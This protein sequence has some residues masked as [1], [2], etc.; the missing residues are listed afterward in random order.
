MSR[1]AFERKDNTVKVTFNPT[2]ESVVIKTNDAAHGFSTDLGKF[3]YHEYSG[4]VERVID[5]FADSNYIDTVKAKFP[6]KAEHKKTK[7][8]RGTL[9]KQLGKAFHDEWKYLHTKAKP[10]D[11]ELDKAVT[12]CI[13]PKSY[14]EVNILSDETFWENPFVRKD[15]INFRAACLASL[16]KHKSMYDWEIGGYHSYEY[17]KWKESYD[18]EQI[19]YTSLNKTLP[20]INFRIPWYMLS[21]GFRQNRLPHP[22]KLREQIVSHYTGAMRRSATRNVN[23]NI[24]LDADEVEWIETKKA[25][26]KLMCVDFRKISSLEGLCTYLLDYNEKYEGSL[27]GLLRRSEEWHRRIVHNRNR[28]STKYSDDTPTAKL[29]AELNIE[30]IKFLGTVGEIIEEGQKMS[31]CVASYADAAVK[32]RSYIFHIEYK[33]QM[34]TCEITSFGDDYRINQIHGPNNQDNKA[35]EWG[36]KTING[37]ISK[38]LNKVTKS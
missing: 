3:R 13:G 2:K 21:G 11:L 5:Y 19:T 38:F 14:T 35:S 6:V 25:F 16:Y 36:K 7:W 37:W 10:D 22:Y 30:G 33:N 26:K 18:R 34:A 9:Y 17:T 20:A 29:P 28:S 24:L 12:R 8:L 1:F 23:I 31:H 15:C 32:G 4:L 27:I